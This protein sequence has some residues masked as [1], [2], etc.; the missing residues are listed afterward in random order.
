MTNLDSI[1]KNRDITLPT[2]VH[3]VKA[4][5]FTVVMYRCECCTIKKDECWKNW[6]FWTVVLQKT[7]ESPLD[8]KESQPVYLKGNQSW[9][10]IG[11]SDAEAET[12]ILW[13]PDAKNWL[14]GKDW[15]WERL[16]VGGE[17]DDRGWDGCMSSPTWWTWVWASF[18]SLW[19][20]GKPGMLQSMGSQKVRHDW[21]TELNWSYFCNIHTYFSLFSVTFHFIQTKISQSPSWYQPIASLILFLPTFSPSFSSRYQQ[22]FL[23]VFTQHVILWM[24]SI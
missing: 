20:T 16:K 8:C 1:F 10:F 3:L 5:V 24:T 11:R 14:I 18:R 22:D 12:P 4:M 13:P 9:I 19:W 15:F 21:V 6:C 23:Q 17:G 2:N 7:L